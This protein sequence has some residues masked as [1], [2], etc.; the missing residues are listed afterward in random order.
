MLLQAL[1]AIL[2]T[3]RV[4]MLCDISR[5]FNAV[6]FHNRCLRF[7]TCF[8]VLSVAI[9]VLL[10]S[11]WL[12]RTFDSFG[13][14]FTFLS[15]FVLLLSEEGLPYVA[16]LVLVLYYLWSSYNSFTD[17]YQDLA[18][19]LFKYYK[20]ERS[21]VTAIALN[22]DSLLENTEK[23]NGKEDSV[24]NLRSFSPWLANN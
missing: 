20:S 19:E 23:P 21:Q 15:L 16:C 7:F 13:G 24:L 8:I 22:T 12:I 3:S 6:H 1:F 10:G 2:L 9:P 4:A 14:L 5:V 18:L 11:W 17:K